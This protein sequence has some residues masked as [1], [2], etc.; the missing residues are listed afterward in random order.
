MNIVLLCGGLSPERDVSLSSGALI[1]NALMG[2]GHSVCMLD[3]YLGIDVL[4]GDISK[5][6]KKK[7][8]GVLFEYVVPKKEPNLKDLKK[9]YGKE[10]VGRNVLDIC[11][12]AD[13]VFLALHGDIGE[14]GE[15][16]EIFDGLGIRYTGSSARGSRFAMDKGESKRVFDENGIVNAKYVVLEGDDVVDFPLPSVV[17]PIDCG[18]SIGVSIVRR[19]DEF[20]ESVKEAKRYSKSVLVEEYIEGREF[21]VGILDGV[22]LPSIEIVPKNGFYDYK[23]K[24]Q[25]G[26]AIEVCPSDLSEEKE[27]EIRDIALN[28]HEVL[29]LG[30]YSRVDFILSDKDNMFYCL[31]ANTL[32]G[33][34]PTSLLP[35]EAKVVGISYEELCERVVGKV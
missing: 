17:K 35:Q 8:D 1:S 19:K 24:Y 12:Y 30:S 9:K 32:P 27:K 14:N 22:A 10:K 29:G 18:S 34:T 4:D 20:V 5:L 3:L 16:Q 26:A 11:K 7:E 28:V 2:N 25:K 6:F 13:I 31:E 23:N 33:M 21:S 15:L